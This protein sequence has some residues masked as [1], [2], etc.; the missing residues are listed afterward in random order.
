MNKGKHRTYAICTFA[1]NHA[2]WRCFIVDWTDKMA[3]DICEY[4]TLDL[5]LT[6]IQFAYLLINCII[7]IM[8]TYVLVEGFLKTFRSSK[9]KLTHN[10]IISYA[11]QSVAIARF[12]HI[13]GL[14]R[15]TNIKQ[16]RF[17]GLKTIKYQ[18]SVSCI[19]PKIPV[20]Y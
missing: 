1:H 18:S 11:S 3:Y 13:Q 20:Y 12:L 9:T 19:R 16:I 10:F 5:W 6:R 15:R 17:G 8:Y 14:M 4:Y 2:N 7:C